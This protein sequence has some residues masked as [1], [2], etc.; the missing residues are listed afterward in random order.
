MLWL[1]PE[2]DFTFTPGQY[3]TIGAEGIE[4]PYS[5]V[6]APFE[7]EIE[8]FIERVAPE[9]QG[10]LTP[11]LHRL[12]PG[13][14]VT[15]R[16]RAKGLFTLRT[17][18]TH[19]VMVSTVTGIAPFVSMIRQFI[20]DHATSS[21]RRRDRFFVMHGASYQDELMYARELRELS[22]QYP[23]RI[24]YV[25]SVSR[26]SEN[27]NAGWN[28]LTG[29]INQRVQEQLAKW[30]PPKGDTT[31][32]LCGNPGMIEDVKA[33]LQPQGWSIAQEQYWTP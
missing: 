19:H 10:K 14:T 31:I 27:L 26:P 17:S 22:V 4:R 18:A 29:R 13:D 2:I 6:S 24:D 7:P 32:Y 30:S 3:I 33:R 28:G 8:L 23:D 1:K 16:P 15:M 5:I 25:G 9:Q 12:H 11:I 21:V 20:H